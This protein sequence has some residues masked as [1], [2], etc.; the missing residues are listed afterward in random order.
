MHLEGTASSTR[1]EHEG[2]PPAAVVNGGC[3]RQGQASATQR[4]QPNPRVVVV[5]DGGEHQTLGIGVVAVVV[6]VDRRQTLGI[7]GVVA[8]H[9]IEKRPRALCLVVVVVVVDVVNDCYLQGFGAVVEARTLEQQPLL[10]FALAVV[11]AVQTVEKQPRALSFVPVVL[12]VNVGGLLRF[13]DVVEARTL[14]QQPT[15]CFPLVVVM[16]IEVAVAGR[17]AHETPR[18]RANL[19]CMRVGWVHTKASS[20]SLAYVRVDSAHTGAFSGL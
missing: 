15:P 7:G 18:L 14:E 17:N 5:V 16:G 10:C 8:D 9:T 1:W 20:A 2:F 6:V 13:G 12:V 3:S 4:H 19:A 11:V